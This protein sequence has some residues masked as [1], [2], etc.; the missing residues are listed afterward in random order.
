MEFTLI[1]QEWVGIEKTV[2]ERVAGHTGYW[3]SKTKKVNFCKVKTPEVANM[4]LLLL[5]E[6]CPRSSAGWPLELEAPEGY[7]SP[8]MKVIKVPEL[9]V[10]GKPKLEHPMFFLAGDTFSIKEAL[11]TNFDADF[12]DIEF[13]GKVKPAWFMP[14]NEISDDAEK[15]LVAW[16]KKHGFETTLIDLCD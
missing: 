1:E 15:G 5:K 9:E 14:V 4:L 2:F 11:K 12:R 6:K 16:L 8:V 3:Y 13:G 7:I 10:V